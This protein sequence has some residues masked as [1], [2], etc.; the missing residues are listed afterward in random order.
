MIGAGKSSGNIAPVLFPDFDAGVEVAPAVEFLYDD[1]GFLLLG[2]DLIPV[3]EYL[4]L[5]EHEGEVDHHLLCLL[6]GFM[7]GEDLGKLYEL[8]CGVV[9]SIT[10]HILFQI[11]LPEETEHSCVMTPELDH[12]FSAPIFLLDQFFVDPSQR[13]VGDFEHIMWLVFLEELDEFGS[14]VLSDQGLEGHLVGF[15]D[16]RAVHS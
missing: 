4:V 7:A 8:V 5:E 9:V 13:I 14:G 11:L 12:Q 1:G 16:G 10:F 3:V 15:A 6:K 2:Q